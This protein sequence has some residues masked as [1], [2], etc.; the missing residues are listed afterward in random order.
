M[1]TAIHARVRIK[2]AQEYKAKSFSISGTSTPILSSLTCDLSALSSARNLTCRA[3]VVDPHL[4]YQ[5]IDADA[6]PKG[7]TEYLLCT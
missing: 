4:R 5:Q 6:Q 1:R 3:R 2:A 7:G